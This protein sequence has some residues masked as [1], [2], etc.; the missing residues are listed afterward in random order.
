M[1]RPA[2]FGFNLETA[3]SNK[4]Q[5][6]A[7]IA[8]ASRLALAEF[9]LMVST[10][11]EKDID[12]LVFDDTLEPQK[13]DAIFPNN[14]ISFHP[15]GI[16]VLYPME[17]ENRRIERRLEVFELLPDY[18]AKNL[19]DITH[20][21]NSNKFLEGTGSII[22]DHTNKKAYC[23]IASRSDV[24]AF[25]DICKQLGFKAIS[26]DAH[27][28]HGHA[29]YHTNVLLSIGDN[30]IV[31]C[32]VCISDPIERSMVLQQL[33]ATGKTIID[34]DFQQ[35]N[36]FAGNCLEVNDKHGAPK[37]IMSQTAFESFSKEIIDLISEKLEIVSVSIPTIEQIGGGSARCMMLGV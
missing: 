28:I 17:A 35:M 31:L 21:E 10:L 16:S 26:F 15:N 27:D 24:E 7:T 12:V 30:I 6:S 25:E 19:I 2:N 22:Y 29:I 4:F 20:Y 36:Q 33:R 23:A 34:I 11:R 32:S 9:D 3:E 37:L 8:D 5:K 1:V 18:S 13:P 14:W